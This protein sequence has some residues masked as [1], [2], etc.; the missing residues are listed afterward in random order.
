MPGREQRGAV[1]A[2]LFL[3]GVAWSGESSNDRE[4]LSRL[5]AGWTGAELGDRQEDVSGTVLQRIQQ[6]RSITGL[7]LAKLEAAVRASLETRTHQRMETSPVVLVEA[8]LVPID[9]WVET[10]I[11]EPRTTMVERRA[12]SL[13]IKIPQVTVETITKRVPLPP[14]N[15]LYVR[16]RIESASVGCVAGRS[17]DG[18]KSGN[19]CL[20]VN[21]ACGAN[22]QREWRVCAKCRVLF[23]GP[24]AQKSKCADGQP[25]DP[26]D[27]ADYVLQQDSPADCPAQNGWRICSRCASLFYGEY[28]PMSK[29]AAGGTHDQ[30]GSGNYALPAAV[31]SAPSEKCHD[32]WRFCIHCRSL[33]YN[34]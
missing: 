5:E 27:S 26:R 14:A 17:H 25:H 18:S 22:V 16:F 19:Y 30:S 31:P 9:R 8:G 34:R 23:Y 3:A 15:K 20:G 4:T 29:C 11:R 13:K 10:T 33:F 7:D 12:G 32:E 1:A 21:S 2:L 24:H 28:Q 6:T